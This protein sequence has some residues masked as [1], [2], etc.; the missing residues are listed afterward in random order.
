M[1]D[2]TAAVVIIG[3]EVLSGKVRDENGPY[4]IDALRERGVGLLEMRTIG[5]DVS[6]IAST[7][8]ALAQKATHVFTTGGVGPTHDDVTL[9]GVAQAFGKQLVHHPDIVARLTNKY[10]DKL[11]DAHLK[12]A[13]VPEGAT[14]VLDPHGFVPVVQLQNVTVLP[15]VPSLMQH[16]FLRIAHALQGRPFLSHAFLL[17]TNESAIAAHLTA[18]QQRFLQVAIGSYPRFDHGAPFSVKIT[19]DAREPELLRQA[20]D[21]LRQGFPTD[22]LVGET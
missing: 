20:V 6:E 1:Q 12:M 3:A 2:P 11:N 10:Q 22:M 13:E 19:V 7:V 18:V 9:L 8:K 21:A 17:N 15:G 16:C 14:L 5:D 4:L